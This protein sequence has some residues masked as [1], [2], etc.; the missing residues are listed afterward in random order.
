MT[1][2]ATVIRLEVTGS[3]QAIALIEDFFGGDQLPNR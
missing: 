3:P 2:T 1:E